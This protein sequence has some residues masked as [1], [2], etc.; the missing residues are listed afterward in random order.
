MRLMKKLLRTLVKSISLYLYNIRPVSGYTKESFVKNYNMGEALARR[1]WEIFLSENCCVNIRHIQMRIIRI[2]TKNSPKQA[3]PRR[4]HCLKKEISS[5]NGNFA[6]VYMRI[7]EI[8]EIKGS[9]TAKELETNYLYSAR[10]KKPFTCGLQ[11]P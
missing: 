10:Q 2:R 7:F 5:I 8:A 3:K 9:K 4:T 1:H 11:Q 6:Q